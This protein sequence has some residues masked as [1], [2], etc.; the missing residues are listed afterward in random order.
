MN[1]THIC[2]CGAVTEELTYQ[3]NLLPKYQKK[4]GNEVTVITSNWIYNNKGEIVTTNIGSKT[5]VDGIKIVRIK[6]SNTNNY[7][8]KFKQFKDII[9]VLDK[10][11]P[12]FIF[13]HGV[14]FLD[15]IKICKYLK[16]KNINVVADNHADY[17]NSGRNFISKHILHGIIWRYVVQKCDNIIM[18]YYGV[19]PARVDFLKERY[20]LSEHKISYLPM[21]ADDEEIERVKDENFKLDMR[22]RLG[23][24]PENVVLVTGGKI[25]LAKKQTLL[26]MKAVKLLNNKNIKLLIF[27]SVDESI[28]EDFEALLNNE[29]IIYLGWANTKQSY[30]YFSIADVCIFPGRHSVYWEQVVGMGIPII[31]KHWEGT[32]HVNISDN[33]KFVY[34]DTVDEWI[35]ILKDNVM[36]SNELEL[37]KINAQNIHNKK[38][39]YG[40]I[41]KQSLEYSCRL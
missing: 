15:L 39:T 30:D 2:L 7:Y 18:H 14:Q 40:E 35:K 36:N 11:E 16:N 5:N 27:G 3:D 10:S 34:R 26:L 12:D 32:T 21:G 38:F 17:S 4:L 29:N 41:A 1:I 23:I 9:Y 37:L 13:I 19:M 25:D 24:G 22:E 6:C 8:A 33:A 20:R 31:C 28:R